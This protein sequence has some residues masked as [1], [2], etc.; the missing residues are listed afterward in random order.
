VNPLRTVAIP[1]LVAFAGTAAL[2]ESG[3][4]V[5]RH[6]GGDHAHVHADLAAATGEHA[7]QHDHD[8]RAHRHRRRGNAHPRPLRPR[9]ARRGDRDPLLHV[10]AASPYQ[11][12]AVGTVAP[13]LAPC[14]AV[15]RAATAPA[16]PTWR[17][18]R[19][20]IARGPP[21]SAVG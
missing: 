12:A 17:A 20:R 16:T 13:A 4:V 11:R 8:H 3:V 1:L 7:Q 18:A 10:H 19:A 5:H 14:R 9:L 21:S 2:P 6:A 15:T